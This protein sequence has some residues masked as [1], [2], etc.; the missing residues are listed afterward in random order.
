MPVRR[1]GHARDASAFVLPEYTDLVWHG[2]VPGLAPGQL[3]GYRVYGPYEPAQ[4]H[5]FNPNKLLLDPYA[6][7][8][9]GDFHWDDAV[10][11]YTVGHNDGDLSFDK[12]DSARVHSEVPGDRRRASTWE[13]DVSPGHAWTETVIYETHVRGFT[14][15]HPGVAKHRR[16]T[17][18]GLADPA[19]IAYLKDLGITAVELLPVHAHID[20]AFVV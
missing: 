5:R 17:F 8:I 1:V 4:G 12:R 15:R 7:R 14:M 18:S 20:E 2:Y 9:A 19:V 6:R 13:D 16:G 3:Y 10:Y 11:G